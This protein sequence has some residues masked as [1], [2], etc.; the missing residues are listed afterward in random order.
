MTTHHLHRHN[1]RKTWI[2]RATTADEKPEW[3]ADGQDQVSLRF[4]PKN[5]LLTRV[6]KVNL[7]PRE[8]VDAIVEDT[9]HG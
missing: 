2:S 5:G 3:V 8:R 7:V 4:I 9:R 1:F 6:G